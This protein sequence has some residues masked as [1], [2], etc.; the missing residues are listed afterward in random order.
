MEGK[1]TTIDCEKTTATYDNQMV[2]DNFRQLMLLDLFL[3]SRTYAGKE[4]E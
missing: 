3:C 4:E 1:S 2:W